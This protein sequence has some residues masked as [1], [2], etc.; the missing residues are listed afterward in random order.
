MVFN[1]IGMD[2]DYRVMEC[3][4]VVGSSNAIK[5][6]SGGLSL[7][8]RLSEGLSG[9]L[10]FCGARFLGWRRRLCAGGLPWGIQCY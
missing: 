4:K 1:G 2:M 8:V 5:E 7:T 10:S 3:L 6:L 9:C